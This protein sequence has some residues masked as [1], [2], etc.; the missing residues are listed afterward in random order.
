M[1][2]RTHTSLLV[3]Y[4]SFILSCA[5]KMSA[6]VRIYNVREHPCV[7]YCI[8]LNCMGGRREDVQYT[9]A[10]TEI[11]RVARERVWQRPNVMD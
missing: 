5:E 2:A 1:S 10:G 7:S 3:S 11:A 9:G 4:V 6:Y 8:P